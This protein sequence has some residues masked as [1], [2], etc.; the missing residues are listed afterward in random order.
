MD[1]NLEYWVHSSIV[2]WFKAKLVGY[3]IYFNTD[4][5][6]EQPPTKIEIFPDFDTFKLNS[7]VDG[8]LSL[9]LNMLVTVHKNDIDAYHSL[10]IFGTARKTLEPCIPVFNYSATGEPQVGTLQRV[11]PINSFIIGEED[12]GQVRC[13]GYVAQYTMQ[14]NT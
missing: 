11:D 5:I 3:P 10:R 4:E 8:D 9:N 6:I 14:V 13:R 12:S 1:A 2:E 7:Q